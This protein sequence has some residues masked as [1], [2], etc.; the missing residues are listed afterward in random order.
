MGKFLE[1]GDTVHKAVAK[2]LREPTEQIRAKSIASADKHS[3]AINAMDAEAIS[4]YLTH[5]NPNDMIDGKRMREVK[6]ACKEN[7]RLKASYKIAIKN[8]VETN[9]IDRSEDIDTTSN[10]IDGFAL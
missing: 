1:L 5:D 3:M 9:D 10:V 6:R 2:G 4:R 7:T 8:L